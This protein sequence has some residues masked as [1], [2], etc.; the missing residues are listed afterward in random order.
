MSSH[1]NPR[2][3][4]SESDIPENLERKLNM[5]FSQIET[6]PYDPVS[7]DSNTI[8][9]YSTSQDNNPK[10]IENKDGKRYMIE[11]KLGEGGMGAVYQ[12]KDVDTG[13]I[14]AMKVT[15]F[16]SANIQRVQKSNRLKT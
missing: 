15:V 16:N 9:D 10:I 6:T 4:G 14:L 5:N 7:S 3:D 11:K 8:V 12:V 1:D 13:E 2:E